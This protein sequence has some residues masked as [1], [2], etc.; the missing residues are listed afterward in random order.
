MPVIDHENSQVPE[1]CVPLTRMRLLK[2]PRTY[3]NLN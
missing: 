1:F 2:I 3:V